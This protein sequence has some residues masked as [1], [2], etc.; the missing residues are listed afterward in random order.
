MAKEKVYMCIDLKS[1]YASVECVERGLDPMKALLAVADPTRTERTICL[2]VTPAMKAL[3]VKNRCR[4]YEIPKDIDYIT[5][6]PRMALYIEYSARIYS[7]YLKYAAKEDIHVYSID[8]VFIDATDYLSYRKQTPKQFAQMIMRD[9][10]ET[11]G[12]TATCG[13]GS[14]LYLAK[15]ALDIIS[16]KSPDHIGILTEE[17]YRETLWRH[18]PLTDFWRIGRGTERRL[19]RL[20]ILTMEDIAHANEQVL[21][22]TFG[23]D[24][25][26]LIDH[27]WGRES[28]TMEDIKS[29]V[30]RTNSLTSGQVLHC[31][32]DFESGR[33]IVREMAEALTMELFEKGL[34][35]RSVNLCLG[36][37]FSAD[38]PPASGTV[39]F[40]APTSSLK[41]LTEGIVGLYDRIRDASVPIHRVSISFNFVSPVTCTQYDMFSSVRE[42]EREAKLQTAML[43][44]R[45]KY[46]KN[47]LIKCTSLQD[48][49]TMMER[50][51]QIGGHRA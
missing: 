41:K 33:I 51:E 46:G 16:K 35:T 45:G 34:C 10:L 42:Q 23:I 13:I 24:A 31:G 30:P 8:E 38:K 47:S 19:Q 21:Y 36:Y 18:R 48:G 22:K 27:A 11:V 37:S 32:Y 14:N 2:A 26:L 29:Y 25:E 20:G 9:V 15:I 28:T 7:I 49:A 12:I 17:S 43:K 50:N 39:S 3:G 5:A 4:V 40:D 44:I 1:F 6:P